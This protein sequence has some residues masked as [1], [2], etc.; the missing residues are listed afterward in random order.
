MASPT[1]KSSPDRLPEIPRGRWYRLWPLSGL[2]IG[3]ILVV[4][5]GSMVGP[6]TGLVAQSITGGELSG[7]VVDA[8]GQPI[9]QARVVAASVTSGWE[10]VE[11][12]PLS[13]AFRFTQV[14][15]GEYELLVEIIGHG[16]VRVVGI[17]IRPGELTRVPVTIAP[18]APPVLRVDTLSL[19]V[20][21]SGIVTPGSG[22]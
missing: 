8:S 13:G 18:A 10:R 20:G 7:L 22:R 11:R 16:P 5:L 4:L 17:P 15:P 6:A 14:P 2:P 9:T 19:D 21:L 1:T 3:P 12:T